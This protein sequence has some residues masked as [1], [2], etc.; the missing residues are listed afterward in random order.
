MKRIGILS[1]THSTYDPRFAIHFRDCDEIWHAGDI[2]DRK[3]LDRLKQITPVVRAVSGNIDTPALAPKELLFDIEEVRVYM[4]HIAPRGFFKPA[5][6]PVNLIVT[7]HSH[8]L[9][10]YYDQQRQVLNINPGA[11]GTYGWQPVRT[12]LRMVIDGANIRDLE[13]IEL[14]PKDSK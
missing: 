5:G 2:G 12:L 6:K 13:V 14:A 7:G 11:A 8:I 10:V 1:D 3:V 9:K 4:T